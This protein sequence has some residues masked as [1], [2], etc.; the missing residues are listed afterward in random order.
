M[1]IVRALTENRRLKSL[2][3]SPG[4]LDSAHRAFASL[5]TEKN[6]T[7]EHLSYYSTYDGADEKVN[8]EIEYY[9]KLNRLGRKDVLGNPDATRAQWVEKLIALNGDVGALFYFL[10]MNP[11]LCNAFAVEHEA[12]RRVDEGGSTSEEGMSNSQNKRPRYE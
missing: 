8:E 12:M 3:V 2:T 5:V 7:L 4:G 10:S 9:L 6:L 1:F 11:A